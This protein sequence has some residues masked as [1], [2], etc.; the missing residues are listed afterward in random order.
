[1]TPHVDTWAEAVH[2]DDVERVMAALQEHLDGKVDHYEAEYQI[3]NRAGEFIWVRDR[4]RV[5]LRDDQGNAIRV[6][7]MLHDITLS[8]DARR[9][10]ATIRQL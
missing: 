5:C 1:M 2:P 6:V 4:G 10:A 3:K 8:K 7:G 9:A